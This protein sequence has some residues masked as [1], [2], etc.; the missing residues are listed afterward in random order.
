MPVNSDDYL[1]A[2][3]AHVEVAKKGK[4]SR[5]LQ[6]TTTV[7][8]KNYCFYLVEE[9]LNSSDEF[10]LRYFFQLKKDEDLKNGIQRFD[11]DR[12]R[13]IKKFLDGKT[14]TP[15]PDNLEFIALLIDFKPRP[16][17]SFHK[18]EGI[19]DVEE[20]NVEESNSRIVVGK[21]QIRNNDS[22]VEIINRKEAIVEKGKGIKNKVILGVL[23]SLSLL[24]VQQTF[25]KKDECMKW[26]EDHYVIVDCLDKIQGIGS[27]EVVKP[28][29]ERE[30][31]RKELTVCDT[32]DF[33]VNGNSKKPKVWY[34]KKNNVVQFFNMDGENPE[35]DVHLKPITPHMIDKY[36][37]SCK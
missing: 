36:V 20:D 29:E 7:S 26:V 13:P 21:S 16:Y 17:N 15:S 11:V 22:G 9:G 14:A 35:N 28:Y 37:K 5:F 33:F 30:F 12:L 1:K 23:A 18:K 8:L 10:T 4:L 19:S 34:S 6:M 31:K 32:T 24:G 3:K 27:Y 2:I 25:F